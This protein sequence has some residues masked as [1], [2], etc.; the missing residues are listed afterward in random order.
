MTCLQETL[1]QCT[2]TSRRIMQWL[3]ETTTTGCWGPTRSAWCVCSVNGD[4]TVIIR[5]PAGYCRRQHRPTGV[6]DGAGH[7]LT[8]RLWS[9]RRVTTTSPPAAAAFYQPGLM[10]QTINSTNNSGQIQEENYA[11]SIK[12]QRKHR[13][14]QKAIQSNFLSTAKNY[15][16]IA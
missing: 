16:N 2:W 5:P 10:N 4:S 7:D 15:L 11:K 6:Q 8:W 12:R 13:R 14:T 3:C 1:L 9:T